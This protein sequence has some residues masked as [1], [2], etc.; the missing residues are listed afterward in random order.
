MGCLFKSLEQWE[1]EGGIRKSNLIEFPDD[2][3]EKSEERERAFEFAK[4]A[5]LA[6][7]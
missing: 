6:L 5:A 7:K 3:S 2:S 4:A 1:A